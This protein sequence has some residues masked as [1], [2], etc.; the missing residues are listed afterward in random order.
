MKPA[1]INFVKE[2][3]PAAV[4]A[5]AAFNLNPLVNLAKEC[6]N[7]FGLTAYGCSNAYWHGGKTP[8]KATSYPLNFRRYDTRENSFLDFARLIRN[9]YRSAWQVSNN[10]QAYAKEIAYSPYISELN[11]DNRETYRHSIIQITQTIQAVMALIGE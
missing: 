4:S 8:V 2:C 1:Q 9:N 3:L 7:Y 5:G 11:G 10:P 6:R